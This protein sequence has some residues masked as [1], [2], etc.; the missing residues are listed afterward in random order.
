M[1]ITLS[2]N[3]EIIDWEHLAIV[4]AQA[5]LGVREPARLQQV[6][7]NSQVRCFA[8]DGDLLIGAG[9]AITDWLSYAVIFD[10]VL[11]QAYQG[12]GIGTEIVGYLA[13][14][15]QAKNVLLHAVPGKEG[16]YTKLGYRKM[17]TAMGLFAEPERQRQLG[18]IE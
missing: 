3:L 15:A 4:F 12:R 14:R 10:V 2:E 9:R 18:Y 8:Y 6:F 16:F 7:R 5:P 17:K 1:P 13:Q 11:F